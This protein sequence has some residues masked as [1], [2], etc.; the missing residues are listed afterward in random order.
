MSRMRWE[1]TLTA[2]SDREALRMAARVGG[3]LQGR[4]RV[5]AVTRAGAPDGMQV[6]HGSVALE[7]GE[8][9]DEIACR[10]GR[11]WSGGEATS[12]FHVPGVTHAVW[13]LEG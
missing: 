6:V 3:I 10:L 1:I 9:A 8:D 4:L 7:P 13:V 11:E 5:D 12:A 2:D